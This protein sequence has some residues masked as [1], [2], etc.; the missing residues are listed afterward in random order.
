MLN[1]INIYRYIVSP[2]PLPSEVHNSILPIHS[3]LYLTALH[4]E[5]LTNLPN[6]AKNVQHVIFKKA[7][8]RSLFDLSGLPHSFL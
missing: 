7:A 1:I 5:T 6:K 2:K 3:V 4:F 8:P